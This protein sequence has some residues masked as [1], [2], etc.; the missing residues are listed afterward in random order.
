[1]L[2]A[3]KGFEYKAKGTEKRESISTL[4]ILC[5]PDTLRGGGEGVKRGGGVEGLQWGFLGLPLL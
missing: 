3:L 1:V 2:Q 4:L 5:N